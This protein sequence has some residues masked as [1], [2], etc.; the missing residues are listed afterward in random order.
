[1]SNNVYLTPYFPSLMLKT[2]MTEF[3]NIKD[4]L[5]KWIIDYQKENTSINRSNIGGW[6]SISNIFEVDDF[7]KYSCLIKKEVDH[8]LTNVLDNFSFEITE[9]WININGK[10]NFNLTHTHP[11][12]DFSAV[13]WV[14]TLGEKSGR[15]E[16]EN[17][18]TFEQSRVLTKLK[19]KIKKD[20]NCDKSHWFVPNDGVLLM[21]PSNL[22]H[23]VFPNTTDTSR[24]SISFNINIKDK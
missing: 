2:E 4:E 1:M 18:H 5:I 7:K 6:H 16:F 9:S 24:I 14:L 23:M 12:S 13:L 8:C 15:L 3:N 10:G 19:Q 21:F 22:R 20:F 17:P 11:E